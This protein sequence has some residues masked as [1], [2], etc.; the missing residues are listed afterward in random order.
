MSP[1][2]VFFFVAVY[3]MFHFVKGFIEGCSGVFTFDVGH[4]RV[5]ALNFDHQFDIDT[6]AFKFEGDVDFADSIE[7]SDEFFGFLGD[8]VAKF[9]MDTSVTASDGNLH[10]EFLKCGA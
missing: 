5:K 7:I 6:G 8:V 9:L 3:L 4:D 2:A 10:F 1:I